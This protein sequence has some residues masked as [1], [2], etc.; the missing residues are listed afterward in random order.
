MTLTTEPYRVC[1]RVN[2]LRDYSDEK[3][4][5]Y[6]RN[7]RKSG[8]IT[9]VCCLSLYIF[10]ATFIGL[11][12]N[13]KCQ[14]TLVISITYRLLI[15]CYLLFLERNAPNII[16][17][18]LTPPITKLMSIISIL[19]ISVQWLQSLHGIYMPCPNKKF[20]VHKIRKLMR[21][22]IIKVTIRFFQTLRPIH[23]T[24]NVRHNIMVIEII[25]IIFQ[26]FIFITHKFFY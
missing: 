12:M 10:M 2:I 14:Q 13:S 17:K 8:S 3:T 1:R 24:K 6:P 21:V 19:N 23:S 22:D 25:K 16:M 5:L 15:L 18:V 9:R 11:I 20:I 26:Y 7:Q 4:K